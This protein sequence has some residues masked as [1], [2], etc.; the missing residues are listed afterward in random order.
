[1]NRESELSRQLQELT[2]QEMHFNLQNSHSAV[3]YP[4]MLKE[5]V[6]TVNGNLA[7]CPHIHYE[8]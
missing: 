8:H 4:E 2:A 6:E 1:M 7:L 5:T 3:L